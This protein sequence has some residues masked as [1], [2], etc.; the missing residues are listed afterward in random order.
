[1][2][3]PRLLLVAPFLLLPVVP[4]AA[5]SAVGLAAF[6]PGTTVFAF[7]DSGTDAPAG[8]MVSSTKPLMF[9]DPT[10][11]DPSYPPFN[12]LAFDTLTLTLAVPVQ[13]VGFYFGSNQSSEVV[14]SVGRQGGIFADFSLAATIDPTTGDATDNWAFHGFADLQDGIDTLIFGPNQATAGFQVGIGE[15]QTF[16]TGSPFA[17][18]EPMTLAL[19]GAGL[20]GLGLARARRRQ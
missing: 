5:P 20:A 9:G 10:M 6:G 7:P 1:M 17:V 8:V 15:L 19:F 4:H 13:G 12:S 2:R 16:G 11:W 14:V 3:T 18:P